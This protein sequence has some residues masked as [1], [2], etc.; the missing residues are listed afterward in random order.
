MRVNHNP[1][2]PGLEPKKSDK[3][4]GEL[5]LKLT[6]PPPPQSY[7]Y[8]SEGLS[9]QDFVDHWKKELSAQGF[10]CPEILIRAAI[11]IPS[12]S[13][14]PQIVVERIFTLSGNPGAMNLFAN[15]PSMFAE[16]SD[17]LRSQILELLQGSS[18]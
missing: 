6:S 16:I 8:G 14:I 4:R 11:E 1:Y 2:L 10:E 13:I 9:V 5:P 18:D 12:R 15:I 7:R 17:G 3:P